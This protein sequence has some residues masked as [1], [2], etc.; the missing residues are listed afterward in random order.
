MSM[1]KHLKT[2]RNSHIFTNCWEKQAKELGDGSQEESSDE[3]DNDLEFTIQEIRDTLFEPCFKNC[4]EIYTNLKSG[5]ATFEVVDEFLADFKDKYL[6]LKNEFKILC[7]LGE[8]DSGRWISDRVRQ[9]EQYHQLNVAF[10]SAKVIFDVKSFLTLK[11][12]FKALETLLQFVSKAYL[13][14]IL[15]HITHIY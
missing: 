14:N 13:C 8:S 4:K 5:N 11:G 6:E 1:A 10:R 9:I 7:P 15:L 2:F 3:S 12:D